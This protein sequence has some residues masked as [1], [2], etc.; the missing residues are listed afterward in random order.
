VSN[1]PALRRADKEMPP[2]EIDDFL[3]QA[4]CGRVATIGDNGMPYICPLLFVWHEGEIWFHN[5]SHP[6]HLRM[7]V[8]R[9]PSVCFEADEPGDVYAYGRFQC[10]TGLAYRSVIA[11]GEVRVVEDA[12]SKARFFDHL[13]A[14]YFSEEP[15]R[16]K[17]FYPRL[18][19]VTVYA[20]RPRRITGKA[21]RLPAKDSLWPLLDRTMSPNAVPPE[22]QRD[23]AGQN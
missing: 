16:P 8:L 21:S 19:E 1:G 4:Y 18:D 23:P 7:N 3:R 13:M 14:K 15:G 5:T 12:T 10:D 6:G 2:S 11:F 22:G 9:R 17:S 20:V